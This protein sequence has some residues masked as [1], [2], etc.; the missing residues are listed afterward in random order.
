MDPTPSDFET[1][2]WELFEELSHPFRVK[3]I[4][5]LHQSELTF[6][7]L[8]QLLDIKSSGHLT[9]HLTKLEGLVNRNT[10]GRYMIT[11]DGQEA[12]RLMHVMN[13]V[14]KTQSMNREY[15]SSVNKRLQVIIMSLGMKMNNRF[16]YVLMVIAFAAGIL[17]GIDPYLSFYLEAYRA[18]SSFEAGKV[19]MFVNF[20]Y[21]AIN[22]LILF[23]TSFLVGRSLDVQ[24][25]LRTTIISIYVGCFLGSFIGWQLGTLI[26]A[27]TSRLEIPVLF[28]I[29]AG[30]FENLR[31]A[32]SMF[33]VSFSAISIASIRKYNA[34]P[35]NEAS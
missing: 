19:S 18:M 30:T 6:G 22:P 12:V 3:I 28:N 27:Y 17:K 26:M 31:S 10:Q 4:N 8:K 7:E 24:A 2:K 25:E 14:N 9:F 23:T 13:N 20:I 1:S 21:Y 33:F 5:A 35:K 32:I 29:L 15:Q 11:E 34:K 16:V